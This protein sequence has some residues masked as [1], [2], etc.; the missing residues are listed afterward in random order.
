MFSVKIEYN[1]YEIMADRD[2]TERQL[3]LKSG[4]SHVTINNILNGRKDPNL[5]TIC[6]LAIA[7]KVPAEKLYTYYEISVH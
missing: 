2:M 6:R 5:M 4:I 3:A 1:L 7:L